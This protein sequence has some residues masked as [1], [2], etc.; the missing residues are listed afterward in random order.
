MPKSIVD[1]RINYIRACIGSRSYPEFAQDLGIST[2]SVARWFLQTSNRQ[3]PSEITVRAI[4]LLD[5]IRAQG[6]EPPP[7]FS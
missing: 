2:P 5:F 6:L 3:N 1:S 7:P 4:Q